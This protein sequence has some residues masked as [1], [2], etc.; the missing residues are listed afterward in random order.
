[1]NGKAKQATVL[2]LVAHSTLFT[3]YH[4]LRLLEAAL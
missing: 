4:L 3:G 2:P 1:M